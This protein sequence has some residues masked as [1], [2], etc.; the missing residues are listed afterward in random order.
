MP[1]LKIGPPGHRSLQRP[2]NEMFSCQ[3]CTCCALLSLQLRS[4]FHLAQSASIP[5]SFLFGQVLYQA[6]SLQC[7]KAITRISRWGMTLVCL[8]PDALS[9]S[10]SRIYGVDG[11]SYQSQPIQ[12]PPLQSYQGEINYSDRSRPLYA[13]YSKITQEEDNKMAERFQKALDGLL[14]FVSP[15]FT[16][17][18]LHTSIESRR[19]AYSQPLSLHCL[20]SQSQTSSLALRIPLPST[21]RKFTSFL[22]IKTHL[23]DWLHLFWFWLNHEYSL[24]QNMSSGLTH[25]GLWP[26]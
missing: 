24:H 13:M 21:L 1:S 7:L 15:H 8:V 9:C 3:W 25:S 22:Q 16:P 20:Q 10:R 6:T 18:C 17:P 14:V 12:P 5:S 19:V 23:M 11:H 2:H 4:N 26:C